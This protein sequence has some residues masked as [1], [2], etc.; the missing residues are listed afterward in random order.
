MFAVSRRRAKDNRIHPLLA[1]AT[2]DTVDAPTAFWDPKQIPAHNRSAGLINAHVLEEVALQVT[3]LDGPQA[4]KTWA[5]VAD[6]CFPC[7]T[8]VDQG[9][10]NNP[11]QSLGSYWATREMNHYPSST[12]QCDVW[13]IS[14]IDIPLQQKGYK[15]M[16]RNW[17]DM[18]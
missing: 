10:Q 1:T 17:G 18:I 8:D 16:R 5:E 2:A 13:K 12:L 11:F 7:C 9:K 4:V 15:S 6:D 3:S 14:S